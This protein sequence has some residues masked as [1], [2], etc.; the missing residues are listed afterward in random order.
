MT[1]IRALIFD[2]DGT[3]F[4]FQA[5]WS[6]WAERLLADIAGNDAALAR[7][8][9]GAMGYDPGRPGFALDSVVIAETPEVIAGTILDAVP[10]GWARGPLVDRINLHARE[11]PMVAAVPLV[12]LFDQLKDLGLKIGLATNDAEEPARRHLRDAGIERH[13]DFVAGYDS[14]HGAKPEPG[15]LQAFA[16]GIGVEPEA[17]AMIGDSAHDLIAARAARMVPVAVLT[18]VATEPELRPL[19]TAVLPDIGH[20]P[21]WLDH[22]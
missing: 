5:T 14:G 6:Q 8:I 15:Q 4:G 21:A 20:I 1:E 9:A 2:K 10:G 17:I 3:L 18:G 22:G 19:A 12:P 7:R 11:T 16:R 13:F